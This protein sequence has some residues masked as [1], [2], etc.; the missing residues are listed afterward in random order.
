MLRYEN[1]KFSL[2]FYFFLIEPKYIC[3]VKNGI[4]RLE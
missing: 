4:F 1:G 3:F 2:V